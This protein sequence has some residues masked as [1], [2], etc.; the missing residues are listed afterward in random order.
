MYT[1][2]YAYLKRDITLSNTEIYSTS[3][4]YSEVSSSTIST[5]ALARI[6]QYISTRLLNSISIF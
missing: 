4:G 3:V 1:T 2:W 6:L 5:I